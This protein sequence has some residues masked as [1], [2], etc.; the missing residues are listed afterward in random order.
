MYQKLFRTLIVLS[1][2]S[3]P[4]YM[5][6]FSLAGL[7]TNALDVLLALTIFVGLLHALYPRTPRWRPRR[8]DYI[9][10]AVFALF[11]IG[12]LVATWSG[13]EWRTGL[14][15]LKSWI[16]L[17]FVFAITLRYAHAQS[18]TSLR[19]VFRALIVAG[20]FVALIALCYGLFGITT[21]D[22]RLSAFYIS[23]N[24][25]A[26]I[27]APSIPLTIAGFV[28]ARERHYTR[29]TRLFLSFALPLLFLALYLT[30][31]FGGTI[32]AGCGS[33]FFL[34]LYYRSWRVLAVSAIAVACGALITMTLMWNTPRVQDFFTLPERSSLAS[35]MM[36][37]TAAWDIATD[38][39]LT[40][41]GPGNF[42]NTYLDYQQYYPPYLEWAVPQPHNLFLA[43]WLQAGVLGALTFIVIL[44]AFIYSTIL[45]YGTRLRSDPHF[46]LYVGATATLFTIILHGLIDTPIWKND[47][48][49]LFWCIIL[50]L[51]VY[52]LP[53]KNKKQ[54]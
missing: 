17:P 21:Y 3:T 33:L 13:G 22:H 32:A 29:R 10:A 2:V 46:F 27:L 40:G 25:L 5:V 16:I 42:Q 51:P 45:L 20:A 15:I 43:F 36:I 12:A 9:T 34:A 23:P 24:H 41:I 7:P 35:R 28:I 26:M 1:I 49:I 54:T 8:H 14:G 48:S 19:D 4:L 30:R 11:L 39:P 37:W 50:L 6:R 47:L 52:H 31:S 38:H 44:I 53:A 18:I